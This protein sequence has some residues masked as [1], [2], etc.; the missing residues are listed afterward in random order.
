ML[1][2]F[3]EKCANITKWVKVKAIET[4]SIVESWSV[5]DTARVEARHAPALIGVQSP[6][7]NPDLNVI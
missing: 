6:V 3:A 4:N 1:D 7:P 2:E 5:M